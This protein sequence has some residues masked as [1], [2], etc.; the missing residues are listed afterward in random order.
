MPPTGLDVSQILSTFGGVARL[1]PLPS[2][3]LFP[4]AIAPLKVFEPRYVE[5][6]REAIDDDGLIALALLKP[7]W[8]SDYEGNPPLHE[9]VCLGRIIQKR[10]QPTGQFSLVLYGIARARIEEE[11]ESEPFRR[12]RVRIIEDVLDPADREA[13]ADHLRRSLDLVPAVHHIVSEVRRMAGRLRGV[14]GSP[15]RY[16]DAIANVVPHL[17]VPGRYEI[18][19]ETDVRRRFERLIELLEEVAYGD[20][21]PVPRG[22]DP[23]RN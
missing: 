22:T 6:T 21:P 1:F 23:S 16:A 19:A 15:G 7:G 10:E 9:V 18:L 13:V 17:D 5:M 12:A 14:D 8:Q 3:V 4:D 2:T 20:A 11:L